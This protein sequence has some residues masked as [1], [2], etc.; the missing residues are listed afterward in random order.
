MIDYDLAP[1][2]NR[3]KLQVEAPGF[4]QGSQLTSVRIDGTRIL[5]GHIDLG[6]QLVSTA[7]LSSSS[8]NVP[9]YDPEDRQALGGTVP[10]YGY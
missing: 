2:Y 3:L 9:E 1:T 4:E 7:D 5:V 10:Y 8:G 6:A